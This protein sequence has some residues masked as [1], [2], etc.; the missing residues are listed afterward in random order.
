VFSRETLRELFDFTT[1]TWETYGNSLRRLPSDAIAR[2]VPG[3]D[4]PALRNVLFHAAT[5][6]DNWLRD[7]LGYD[8]PLDATSETVTSWDELKEHRE[9]TRGWLRRVIDETPEDALQ[10]VEQPMWQGT[11]AEMTVS[12]AD[13]LGHILLHERGHHGDVTTMLSQLGATP[14]SVDYLTYVFF[15]QRK[16][17]R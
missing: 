1:F 16:A 11:A 13:I 17:Q 6:W 9:R 8:D 12:V 14:P 15:K 4:W 5:S 2:P 3:S 10:A 7:R